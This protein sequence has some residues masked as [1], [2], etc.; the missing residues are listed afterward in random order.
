MSGVR[1]SSVVSLATDV[2]ARAKQALI[3]IPA[4]ENLSTLL[5]QLVDVLQGYDE[6]GLMT[7]SDNAQHLLSELGEQLEMAMRAIERVCMLP[8]M[9]RAINALRTT[10][11][12]RNFCHA[13]GLTL[14]GLHSVLSDSSD[15]AA[16]RLSEDMKRLEWGFR[17][18]HFPLERRDLA[19]F[20]EMRRI[21]SQ[22]YNSELLISE[23]VRLARDALETAFGPERIKDDWK[24]VSKHLFQDLDIARIR[25]DSVEQHSI[26]LL[27]LALSQNDQ[28]PPEFICPLTMEV[29]EDPVVL[30]E[31]AVTVER[32]NLEMWLYAHGSKVC[33]VSRKPL[34]DIRF[35]ENKALRVLI[36]D[37]KGKNFN[38][39]PRQS[40]AHCRDSAQ[41]LPHESF[42]SME[43]DSP[44]G[45][46]QQ[47]EET[48]STDSDFFV[49]HPWL[50]A[51]DMDGIFAVPEEGERDRATWGSLGNSLLEFKDN[52]LSQIRTPV[53]TASANV[54]ELKTAEKLHSTR[55]DQSSI[56]ETML[57]AASTVSD[58]SRML[59]KRQIS[60]WDLK[61][62]IFSACEDGDVEAIQDLAE[63]GVDITE[64]DEDGRNC[65]HWAASKGQ[66]EVAAVL[67]QQNVNLNAQTEGDKATPLFIATCGGHRRVVQLLLE[68]N[69]NFVIGNKHGWTPLHV[70]ADKGHT[71]ICGDLLEHANDVG[72]E[73]HSRQTEAGWTPLHHACR[74]G[75]LDAARVLVKY[76]SDVNVRCA[77][78]WTALHVAVDNCHGDLVELLLR[79]TNANPNVQSRINEESERS[80]GG[81]TPLHAAQDKGRLD[82]GRMLLKYGADPDVQGDDGAT[83][84]HR[85]CF[86]G[87]AEFAMML[88][89]EGNASLNKK[90][91]KSGRKA[92]RIASDNNHTE[93][94]NFLYWQGLQRM[95]KT[96]L[97]SFKI[98]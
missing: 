55:D 28:A 27:L 3:S 92:I 8:S 49:K 34:D 95:L 91:T 56:A 97:S 45:S 39:D 85:A 69:A 41:S 43:S 72:V 24:Q 65:L 77:A 93:L 90:M 62:E 7:N 12:F 50:P 16:E 58:M 83:A 48:T 87:N 75:H 31:T 36:E 53:S 11:D 51:R 30:L 10:T 18:A 37:W 84:L 89:T 96:K 4:C 14:E 70:A 13:L 17:T 40:L 15:A 42:S 79:E 35:A 23:A 71:E 33:P 6:S 73:C 47:H 57:V 44:V 74:N 82:I 64:V 5:H 22:S 86:M 61:K 32:R 67:I 76:M 60:Y 21:C 54:S 68:N 46:N 29:M 80:G 78:G 81:W 38:R 19:L 98:L 88:V 26:R 66:T 63:N 9:Y 2:Y 20:K 25:R 94:Y 59:R 1:P 52:A